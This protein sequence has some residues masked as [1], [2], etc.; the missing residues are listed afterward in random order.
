MSRLL[1]GVFLLV[2]VVGACGK[3]E[4]RPARLSLA[5]LPLEL[6]SVGVATYDLKVE[7]DDAETGWTT[8]AEITGIESIQGGSASYVGP[9]VPGPSRVTVTLTQLLTPG[10]APAEV[11]LPPPIQ[12]PFVCVENADTFVELDVFV[13]MSASQGFLDLNLDLDDLFCSAK[14]DCAAA[15][16]QHPTTG[17]RGP[18]L[19]TGLACTGGADTTV[20]EN[21]VGFENAV[22]CC[23]D[24]VTAACTLLGQEPPDIGVLYTQT[25]EGTEE[26]AGKHFFNTAWRLDDAWLAAHD[27]HCTF[28]AF[29]FVT[30]DP[31]GNPPTTYTEGMPAV[32]Y[33]AEINADGSC[34]IGSAVTVAYTGEQQQVADCSPRPDVGPFEP[35]IC[36]GIDNDCDGLI[37]A[38]DPDLTELPCTPPDGDGDGV[39]DAPD[40]CPTVPNADQAD[41]DLD[42]I[43]DACDPDIDGDGLLNGSDNCPY[44]FN[45][46]QEDSDLD[47][48]GDACDVGG[49][50][51]G[52]GNL[53]A[54][55]QCDLGAAT[56]SEDPN[57]T[58]R[59][60]CLLARCGDGVV[61]DLAP[62]FEACDDGN[63][64]DNDT[65]TNSCAVN[66]PNGVTLPY[67]EG[68]DS[69]AVQMLAL[70]A[71]EVPWW[72]PGTPRWQLATAGPLGPD[73]HP[74]YLYSATATG[75]STQLV[76]PLLDATGASQL[77]FQF[78]AAL[79]P[80]GAGASVTFKAEISADAGA[81]WT[82]LYAHGTD[83]PLE[84]TIVTLDV[85]PYVANE[86]DAQLRFLVEGGAAADVLYIEVDDV[87]VAEGHAPSLG[88][89]ADA[90]A[91]QD[92]SQ[93]LAVTASDLDTPGAGL[94]FGLVGPS[95]ATL[96]DNGNGSATIALAPVEADI[97]THTATVSVSDGIFVDEAT[98]A[99]TVTPPS[100]GPGNPVAVILVR[101]APGGV[102]NLVGDL[103]LVV[104]ESDTFYAAGYDS[105]LDYIG[106]TSVVWSTGGS[107]PYELAGPQSS[108]TFAATVAGTSGPVVASHPDPTVISGATGTITVN[109][110]PPGAPSPSVSTLTA[111]PP[112]I[113]ADG[114][115]TATVTVVVK[116]ANGTVLT[117]P[118]TVVISTT[119]GTLVGTVADNGNGTYT[120]QL[121][122]AAAPAIATLSAT[123]DGDPLT[124]TA[125]VEFA[126]ATHILA[127]TTVIN[128]SNYATYQG[129]DLIITG[130]TLTINS[131]G[132][133]PMEFGAVTVKNDGANNCKIV[134][135]E[136]TRA[137]WYKIDLRVDSLRVEPGCSIN[138]D[139]RGYE[140]AYTA[141][142]PTG[143]T[144]GNS[145]S[146][147]ASGNVGGT[148][149]GYGANATGSG[150][151]YGDMR[152]PGEPGAGGG[153]YDTSTSYYGGDGGGVV[154]IQVNPGG[155]LVVD[156][157]IS[158]NG[159]HRDGSRGSGGAGGSIFLSTPSLTGNG[160]ITA[161]GG[162]GNTTYGNGGGGGR[163]AIV[164]LETYGARFAPSAFVSYVQAR[165]GT[166][167]GNEG[168]AGTAYVEYPG[169]PDGRL[170]VANASYASDSASTKLLCVPPGVLDSVD[171]NGFVDLDANLRVGAQT[172]GRFVGTTVN[173]KSGQGGAGFGDDATFDITAH[174]ASDVSLNGDASAVAAAG[175]AYRGMVVVGHLIVTAGARLDARGCDL[176][177]KGGGVD[178]PTVLSVNGQ[179]LVEKADLGPIT[180]INVASGGL[181]V[182]NDLI[183]SNDADFR[184]DVT[185][186]GGS[187]SLPNEKLGSLT[188]QS[189]GALTAATLD[190]SGAMLVQSD[191]DVT[192]S[193]ATLSAGTL[194]IT[195]TGSTLTH[196]ATSTGPTERRLDI[197]ADEVIVDS[198]GTIDVSGRGWLGGNNSHTSGYAPYAFAA[199]PA[200]Q[201]G[202]HGGEGARDNNVADGG[203]AYGSLYHPTHN[204]AGGGGNTSY[205]DRG[206][207]GGGTIHIVAATRAVLNGALRANGYNGVDPGSYGTAGG[208]GGSIYVEAPLIQGN[209]PLE[210]YGGN[211]ADDDAAGGGGGRIALI[212]ADAITD[213]PGSRSPYGAF[214][215][216]GGVT[217]GNG[218]AGTFYRRVGSADGDLIIDN[219]GYAAHAYTPLIF[220]GSGTLTSALGDPDD[221]VEASASPLF[222]A[223][224]P[225]DDY[226][227]RLG[228]GADPVSLEDDLV[229]GVVA[230]DSST[231][232]TLDG[233][234]VAAGVAAGTPWSAYYRFDNL[235]V[236]GA[237]W[238]DVHGD[239]R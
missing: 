70:T 230:T 205:A 188:V 127:L 104:G 166:G 98:F 13:V 206:G 221:A 107:L 113:V 144:Q 143:Y 95:F 91:A 59:T 141:T 183:G 111:N 92:T 49:Q 28:S 14:V 24:G 43:G 29:G 93:Y 158:A 209:G 66:V 174:T 196:T 220:R 140:G 168:G 135:S 192:I 64:I 19:V 218:G 82:T 133:E 165:G 73:P 120:Q 126:E 184:F 121:Q 156:G 199:A 45:P 146:G 33:Y 99:I 74:R 116:D 227:I 41:A 215:V 181:T 57:A 115:S 231:R 7:Y 87:T 94:S 142:Y 235:D 23:D 9:C 226:H 131:N 69:T 208:A 97:G 191:A 51:C 210:A 232:L 128:C 194:T 172:W 110:P 167:E 134:H 36:D 50:V 96:S 179:L 89:L 139:G 228:A 86:P 212:A 34:G 175:D 161:N 12:E 159:E 79:E 170:Y 101:D 90:F 35:E 53:E 129:Q 10:G 124:H 190:V 197:T 125:T 119:A 65:C 56:N 78:R 2:T 216:R 195:G 157:S 54:P 138:V 47:G 123:I 198:G 58:C 63:T 46:L 18:T 102:G 84:P 211:G 178:D 40:N 72:A 148:H 114:T 38:A 52:D 30:S 112:G 75:M 152:N 83:A 76:S 233:D 6:P 1:L 71:A 180:T 31:G 68:F 106:D 136:T 173:P 88:A 44:D 11:V 237:A 109:A 137:A 8:V 55:E 122:S 238:L 234:P 25:Y 223:L 239:L 201:G 203:E 5:I 85:S 42:G 225:I 193:N 189:A 162:R 204:G 130:G 200:S 81:S 147:G 17:E 177:V 153:K 219:E 217:N 224:G 229:F 60:D 48:F 117:D 105:N 182:T 186:T 118:H 236:R 171:A 61:D 151:I 39:A 160:T 27:A 100:Q 15:L 145:A 62:R 187:S 213:V 214:N 22:L 222:D 202:G 32:H 154:R 169:E 155:F 20:D 26:I 150:L 185:L 132:C 16:L 21:Y 77:T 80:N 176:W 4:T 37:D 163:V 164:G 103:T 207:S 149:G 3:N 67:Y 108:F